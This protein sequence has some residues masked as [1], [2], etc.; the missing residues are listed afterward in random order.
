MTIADFQKELLAQGNESYKKFTA[1][2]VPNVDENFI[3]GLKWTP[4]LRTFTKNFF[5]GNLE[6]FLNSLP[7]KY[8][9]ENLIHAHLIS[10]MKN[11][12]ECLREVKKFLPYVDNWGV[13]DSIIP[14]I[15]KK[16]VQEL[17]PEILN[18]LKSENPYAV[19]F[20]LLM[21]LKF[22]LGENFNEKYLAA[23]AEIKSEN[24][25]VQMAAAWFFTEALIKQYDSA[26]I[27][28]EQKK[29]VPWIQ[30]KT[31]QKAVESYRISDAQKNYLRTLKISRG[32][33][34]L[35]DTKNF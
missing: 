17:E 32:N 28:L 9:E 31:I 12:F 4:Q 13:C 5:G 25:Y 14:K 24:Y 7:H 1:K 30:N 29:L 2:L 15:F 11:F 34:K 6:P 26:K 35:D 33:A 10:E 22:Y 8:Y 21:L 16:H 19:R 3:I 20:A 23:A 27:Y 18:F